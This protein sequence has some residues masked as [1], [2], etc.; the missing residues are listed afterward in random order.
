MGREEPGRSKDGG[1]RDGWRRG[2]AR[3]RRWERDGM[4]RRDRL[5][6]LVGE[7][8]IVNSKTMEKF[9]PRLACCSLLLFM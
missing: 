8:E 5:F 2:E 6:S 4:E 3:L 1:V 9:S 7:V